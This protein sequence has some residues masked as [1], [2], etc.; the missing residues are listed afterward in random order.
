MSYESSDRPESDEARMMLEKSRAIREWTAG[1]R[2][3]TWKRLEERARGRARTR[4]R[5][6][7]LALAAATAAVASV[8]IIAS[9]EEP[10]RS[11]APAAQRVG[12]ATIEAGPGAVYRPLSTRKT[13]DTRAWKTIALEV[14]EL[15]ATVD[16]DAS[17]E[18]L[19]V[20]TPQVRVVAGPGAIAVRV[21]SGLTHVV[22]EEGEARVESGERSVVL[23]A[24]EEL[25]SSDDRLAVRPP[26]ATSPSPSDAPTPPSKAGLPPTIRS[27]AL[28]S[29]AAESRER[30]HT[31]D[32]A[33]EATADRRSRCYGAIAKG[34]D[35]AAQNALYALGLLARDERHDSA[36]AV[37]K[38]REYQAR[39]PNG[40]L[41]PEA[42][43]GVLGE[44][45]KAGHH[46]EASKEA[47]RYLALAPDG[48]R[49]GE[50]MLI[51]AHL[52]RE[53]LGALEESLEAYRKAEARAGL[54]D[55][56]AEAIFF[57][58]VV[59]DQLGHPDR[60]REAFVRYLRQFPAGERAA[61]VERRLAR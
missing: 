13:G 3:A 43:L 14:G 25:L 15:R 38:W 8:A 22:V 28:R 11:P 48:A 4:Q 5:A 41:A 45:M 51:R 36:E 9:R 29:T 21:A 60:S 24:G 57:Q 16:E 23:H 50:V 61:E 2:S 54:Q 49:A 26:S 34:D 37:R 40:I 6:R 20:A 31:D 33:E 18:P 35:I 58:G 32:C 52:L 1:G 44:L 42:S 55:V 30:P 27:R 10:A 19:I 59:E 39:F 56:R 53:H 17:D 47:D 46:K 7:V 12:H